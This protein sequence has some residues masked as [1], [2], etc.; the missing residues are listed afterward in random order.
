MENRK[1]RQA[2]GKALTQLVQDAEFHGIV[3]AV[4]N[5]A[6]R[7]FWD[8][9]LCRKLVLR[10][11]TRLHQL[12]QPQTDRLIQLHP[13]TASRLYYDDYRKQ[14]YIFSPCNC[15]IPQIRVI[16]SLFQKQEVLL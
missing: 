5:I 11:S 8:A 2:D 16:I 9:A 10:H 14:W 3:C 1:F 6:D 12:C 4:H 13:I 7:R 15:T